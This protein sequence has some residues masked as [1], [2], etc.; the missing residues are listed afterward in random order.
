M[1][2]KIIIEGCDGV[3]KTTLVN[4][5]KDMF[6]VPFEVV[7]GTRETPNNLEY[8]L[9]LLSSEKP[10]IFDRFYMGQ[11]IYQTE[12]ERK[13]KGWLTKEHREIIEDFISVRS[14]IICIYAK[15]PNE[16]CLYNCSID[17]DDSHYTLEYIK[18]LKYKYAN[19][20]S[21]SKLNWITY[22]NKYIPPALISQQRD[23]L[24][25]EFDYSSLPKI[26]AVDFDG[27]LASDCFPNIENARPNLVLMS[28]LLDE[29]KNGT[30]LILWTCRTGKSL[31]DAIDFCSNYGLKFD[32]VNDNIFE[33]RDALLG[34][35]KK[36]FANEYIDDKATKIKF[37]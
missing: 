36:V 22:T 3:G 35:P 10:M 24:T 6:S 11:F 2:L 30:K 37:E 28:K 26:I 17:S 21:K 16:V 9:R 32:A 18:Q 13:A 4:K 8:Y 27:T 23:K 19:E 15:A 7:H 14:D 29:Q 25:E 1:A 33:V 34:G 31:E 20:I 5:I 12:E